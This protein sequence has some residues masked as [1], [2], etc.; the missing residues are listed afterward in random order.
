MA[1]KRFVK[2][3]FKDTAQIDQPAGRSRE[4]NRYD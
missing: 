2:G 1:E 3:L 4:G